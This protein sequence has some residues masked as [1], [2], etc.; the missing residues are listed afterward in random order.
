MALPIYFAIGSDGTERSFGAAPKKIDCYDKKD[1]HYWQLPRSCSMAGKS[2]LK[3]GAIERIIGQTIT[4]DQ[5]ATKWFG[6]E[7]WYEI[8]AREEKK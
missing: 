3:E 7:E 5:I 2:I 1:G 4:P 6:N 8:L